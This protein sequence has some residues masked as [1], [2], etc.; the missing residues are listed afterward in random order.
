M[1]KTNICP[2]GRL[3]RLF[4]L[5]I[6]MGSHW[7]AVIL[8]ASGWDAGCFMLLLVYLTTNSP[9]TKSKYCGDTENRHGKKKMDVG[10]LVDYEC[11]MVPWRFRLN[12]MKLIRSKSISQIEKNMLWLKINSE[13]DLVGVRCFTH[14][15]FQGFRT[16]GHCVNWKSSSSYGIKMESAIKL[17]RP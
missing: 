3:D 17:K 2:R 11:T 9:A 10:S 6:Q 8:E 1:R 4:G 13:Q 16:Q 15:W 12:S 7:W 14:C 5:L